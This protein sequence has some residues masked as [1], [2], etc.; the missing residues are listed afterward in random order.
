MVMT[1]LRGLGSRE[2]I[3][4]ACGTLGIVLVLA[5]AALPALCYIVWADRSQKGAHEVIAGLVQLGEL[6]ATWERLVARSPNESAAVPA[7][8]YTAALAG[9]ADS[10][11][12]AAQVWPST[13]L[14]TAL[15]ETL[16]AFENKAKLMTPLAKARAASRAALN[17]V[18][19]MEPGI[20][21]VMREAWRD[22]PDRQRLVAL[23]NVVTQG[24]AE[25]QRYYYAGDDAVRR[26]LE[27]TAADLRSA[28]Q[29]LPEGLSA[30]V[31]QLDRHIQALLH[32]RPAEQAHSDRVRFHDAGPRVA[33]LMREV[34]REAEEHAADRD[35]YRIYLATYAVALLVLFAYIAAR[36]IRRQLALRSFGAAGPAA[37]PGDLPTGPVRPTSADTTP[38]A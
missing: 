1:R 10:V 29:A 4:T 2:L 28:A 20:A 13:A 25:A 5:L 7:T 18:L 21:T 17:D 15:P 3:V 16:R 35:R 22:A 33:T 34:R 9:I 14:Q 24:I 8:D 6:D 30:V 23:D 36:L 26:N 11:Q 31:L 19:A 12:A 27:M 38:Q 37:A 32:A